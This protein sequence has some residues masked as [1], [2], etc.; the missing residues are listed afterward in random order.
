MSKIPK[1][2]DAIVDLVLSFRPTPKT[3]SAQT[4]QQ[5]AE[6]IAK[7]VGEEIERDKEVRRYVEERRE[8]IRK[9]ANRAPKGFRL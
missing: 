8:S 5:L 6:K 9:G 3:K 7:V 2:L 1:E 4:R